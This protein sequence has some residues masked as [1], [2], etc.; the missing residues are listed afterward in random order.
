[1]YRKQNNNNNH[2]YLPISGKDFNSTVARKVCEACVQVKGGRVKSNGFTKQGTS[3]CEKACQIQN[4][5]ILRVSPTTV[6]LK[7]NY[8]TK[9]RMKAATCVCVFKIVCLEYSH[10]AFIHYITDRTGHVA[11]L[12]FEAGHAH[13]KNL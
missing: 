4:Q 13:R 2:K 5:K 1:M 11:M 6:T 12:Y 7:D 8:C 10:Y 9:I 3:L